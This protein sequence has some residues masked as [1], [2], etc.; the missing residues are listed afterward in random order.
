MQISVNLDRYNRSFIPG[1]TVEGVV[2]I[3]VT[4][5]TSHSGIKL[6]VDGTVNLQLSPRSVGVFEA[7]YSSIKP[8]QLIGY[9]FEVAKPGKLRSGKTE[10]PFQFKLKP[11]KGCQLHETYHG[12]YINVQYLINVEIARSMLAK[13]LKKTI[14]F[15]VKCKPKKELV[16]TPVE[17]GITPDKLKN[18]SG[19]RA[20]MLPQFKV[21]GQFDSQ[22]CNVDRPFEGWILVEKSDQPIKSIELQFVRVE[23]ASYGDNEIREA[24]EVQNIQIADGDVMRN[25]KIPMY[26]IFPRLFTCISTSAKNWKVSFEVNVVVLFRDNQMLTENFPIKLVR[27]AVPS[28]F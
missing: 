24:T 14:E 23:T 13:N 7:F 11:K 8:V 20:G 25:T 28:P 22:T 3:N 26:M 21:R 9:E 1:E 5:P 6:V 18:V 4:A 17:F 12:V 15:I 16:K 2:E 19:S 27:V 10:F